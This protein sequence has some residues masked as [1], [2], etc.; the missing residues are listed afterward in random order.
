MKEQPNPSFQ[1]LTPQ[2]HSPLVTCSLCLHTCERAHYLLAELAPFCAAATL[3]KLLYTRG[4]RL[5]G[6]AGLAVG[7]SVTW[8]V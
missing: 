1:P 5:P 6:S 2:P 4:S 3:T 7:E 8:E